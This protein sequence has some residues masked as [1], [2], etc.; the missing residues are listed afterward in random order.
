GPHAMP[1]GGPGGPPGMP[2]GGPGAMGGVRPAATDAKTMI[3]QPSPFAQGGMVPGGMAPGGM[4]MGGMPPS[5]PPGPGM[6]PGGPPGPA[7]YN[8]ASPAQKTI[9][10]GLAPAIMGG[11]LMQP[12]QMPHGQMPHGQMPH[13]YPGQQM[14]HG[15]AASGPNK[16][17]M[18]A[19]SEGVV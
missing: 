14:P 11:Q 2:M 3:A 18:L 19:P 13:G 15:V 8:P 16:T 12:G 6:P 4:P 17:V 5:G 9:V 7:G 1:M 10:A